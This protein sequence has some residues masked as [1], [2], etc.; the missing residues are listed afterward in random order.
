MEETF[1][2]EQLEDRPKR[3]SRGQIDATASSPDQCQSIAGSIMHA[4]T[5]QPVTVIEGSLV[6]ES[7][8]IPTSIEVP[9]ATS[10][11]AGVEED[12]GRREEEGKGPTMKTDLAN[13]PI[14]ISSLL[15]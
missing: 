1:A 5:E 15:P 4:S 11:A 12:E 9:A 10:N 8:Q 13:P 7:D 2:N 14:Q 6:E 3:D